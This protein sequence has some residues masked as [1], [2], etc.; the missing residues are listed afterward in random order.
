[1]ACQ[2]SGSVIV[3]EPEARVFSSEVD[4]LTPPDLPTGKD[5]TNCAMHNYRVKWQQFGCDTAVLLK[6]LTERVTDGETVV[7]LPIQC[8]PILDNPPI[9]CDDG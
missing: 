1:M 3:V 7:D 4:M 5:R 6:N 8:A 9:L 2:T